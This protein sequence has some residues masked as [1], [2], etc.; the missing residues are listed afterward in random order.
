MSRSGKPSSN[1]GAKQKAD[2][3]VLLT[4]QAPTFQCFHIEEPRLVFAGGQTAV[5][6]KAGITSFGPL[7]SSAHHARH[8]RLGVI[9][10]SQGIHVLKSYFDRCI[11]GVMPGL[12]RRQKHYDPVCFPDFPGARP[13]T[14]FRANFC[15]ERERDIPL[16]Y[17]EHASKEIDP[18]VRLKEVVKLVDKQL[19]VLC[20]MEPRP[21]VAVIVLPRCVEDACRSIGSR[22]RSRKLQLSPSEKAKRSLMREEARTNQIM[23]GL[24]FDDAGQ[25]E[26]DGFWN[27]HHALKAH[28]MKHG[29][30]TQIAWESTLS[31]EGL[32]QDPATMAWNFFTALFYKA[33]NIP[34]LLET[35]AENTCYVGVAFFRDDPTKNG[36]QSSLAQA[37]SGHGEG[38]VLQGPR[39]IM[40]RKGNPVPHLSEQEAERL[41]RDVLKLY[42]DFHEI[43]PKRVVLHK[44]SRFW[45]EE[46]KGFQK[47]LAGIDRH[48]LIT[49][50][51]SQG[52][53]LL[54]LGQAP[55]VRGTAVQIAPRRY[56]LYT[57]GF[58]PYLGAYPGA[59]VPWPIEILE[60]HGESS[61]EIICS[62]IMSLTKLNWN[63]CNFSCAEP[64]TLQF[65]RVVGSIVRE[66]PA[67][68]KPERRYRF[69]M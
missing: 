54:R 7:G 23:L 48:D 5:D 45:P 44:T 9:G 17:F 66:L 1:R 24:E 46:L 16:R 64:I 13:T 37:F 21:E 2:F 61:P 56:L 27:I 8:V 19:E 53:R 65:A 26:Q 59:H 52:H 42:T 15:I 10:T 55:P 18:S 58:V 33:G 69:Y 22:H 4:R 50:S 38:L 41:L 29:I 39:S 35:M 12:N 3:D 30:P 43:A 6:P 14:G 51:P 25:T 57:T 11:S 34:W 40:D 47:A 67:N 31:G 68:C 28:A 32:T 20:A 63:S 62:E 49:I 36:L 60:H